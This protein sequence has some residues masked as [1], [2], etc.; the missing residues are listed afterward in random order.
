MQSVKKKYI[1]FI[2]FNNGI[3]TKYEWKNSVIDELTICVIE[4]VLNPRLK[5][6]SCDG[7]KC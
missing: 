3:T 7:K 1:F 4:L 5:Y 6:Y 2:I